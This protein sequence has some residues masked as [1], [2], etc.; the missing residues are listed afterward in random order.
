MNIP[1]ISTAYAQ[2]LT[3]D[4]AAE[5]VE[6][7][8]AIAH[9]ALKWG[10]AFAIL[11][12][13][14]VLAAVAKKI[15]VK[16]LSGKGEEYHREVIILFERLTYFV[17]LMIG[18]TISLSIF[19]VD[20]VSFLGFFT[21][22][23]GFALKDL[24][25]NFIAGVVVLNSKK[26]KIGDF[27][28]IGDKMGTISNIETRTTDIKS[29]DGTLLV[30]PNAHLMTDV[31]QNFTSNTVRRITVPI[32][33]HYDTPLKDVIE[34]TLSTIN[35]HPDV[36]P[37]PGAVVLVTEFLDSAISLDVR[38]WVDSHSNWQL[39]RSEVIQVVK[40]AYDKAGV[41]IPFPIRTLS[42]DSYDENIVGAVN[43]KMH[44]K[45]L[46]RL[47]EAVPAHPAV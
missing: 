24:L 34:M 8:T 46:V 26:F 5:Q 40:I 31:V 11:L 14:F 19:E 15:V 44:P 6:W 9:G 42:L 22:G 21:L 1:F 17:V 41:V 27:V 13:S 20:F 30:I 28:K 32:G 38:F 10:G 18:V 23:I 47:A 35:R 25:G 45:D 3:P 39:V 29:I 43:G 33:V 2:Q 16:K 7:F 12:L 36:L 37:D 4:N